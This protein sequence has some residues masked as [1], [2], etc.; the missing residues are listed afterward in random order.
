MAVLTTSSCVTFFLSQISLQSVLLDVF[1]RVAVCLVFLGL[2][3]AACVFALYINKHTLFV[4]H[5][6][7][8]LCFYFS[9]Q[10]GHRELA[11]KGGAYLK[12]T[13]CHNQFQVSILAFEILL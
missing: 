4:H 7:K 3:S 8:L 11:N 5:H 13:E 1:F 2:G 10:G 12:R 9:T 6:D